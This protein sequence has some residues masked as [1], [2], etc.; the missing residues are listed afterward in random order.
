[1][2]QAIKDFFKFDAEK[3]RVKTQPDGYYFY[4]TFDELMEKVKFKS[5]RHF[6]DP[7]VYEYCEHENYG[8]WDR[9]TWRNLCRMCDEA[10]SKNHHWVIPKHYVEEIKP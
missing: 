7:L 9:Y 8:S 10:A 5:Y 4:C 2:F 3:H 1:M 6:S